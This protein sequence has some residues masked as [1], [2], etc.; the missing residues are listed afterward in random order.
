MTGF[1]KQPCFISTQCFHKRIRDDAAG[2]NS[3]GALVTW[4]EQKYLVRSAPS[5]PSLAL[6]G[7]RAGGRDGKDHQ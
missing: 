1:T 4:L 7:G 2:R 5:A 6:E 3:T